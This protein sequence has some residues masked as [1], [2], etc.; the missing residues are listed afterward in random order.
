LWTLTPSST[1][2]VTLTPTPSG[3]M[4]GHW[5]GR[6]EPPVLQALG[7]SSASVSFDVAM[8]STA[9]GG[10][11]QTV[12]NFQMGISVP[13]ST[14]YFLNPRSDRRETTCTVQGTNV[15][16]RDSI[17]SGVADGALGIAALLDRPI[18][19]SG[20]SLIMTAADVWIIGRF[21]SPTSL[22]GVY[23]L[24]KCGN[25]Y[26]V[27]GGL[28]SAQLVKPLTPT[29][30]TE[31]PTALPTVTP[32]TPTPSPSLTPVVSPST[33]K[34]SLELTVMAVMATLQQEAT[35]TVQGDRREK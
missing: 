13:N 27:A 28:W 18:T 1:P 2:T 3:P 23:F 16:I 8:T 34:S 26:F 14:A 5:T 31:T 7:K 11:Q 32:P 22:K 6:D 17:P 35:Q 15:P 30:Q 9:E 21:D 4:A 10:W 29:V 12:T 25:E 20:P 19:R 33:T 24:S